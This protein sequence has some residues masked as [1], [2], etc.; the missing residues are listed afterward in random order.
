[1]GF[2]ETMKKPQ[3]NWVATSG[4]FY[5]KKKLKFYIAQFFLCGAFRFHAAATSLTE[6]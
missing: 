2:L 6:K 3:N 5:W 4:L 1:M